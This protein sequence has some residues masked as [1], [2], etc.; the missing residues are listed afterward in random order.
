MYKCSISLRLNHSARVWNTIYGRMKNRIGHWEGGRY[1]HGFVHKI[2]PR[3][4]VGVCVCV[5]IS[6]QIF[7]KVNYK[8]F[9]VLVAQCRILSY[10]YDSQGLYPYQAHSL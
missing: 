3:V 4:Y 10:E 9:N 2:G 7:L 1:K 8:S 6:P 5:C